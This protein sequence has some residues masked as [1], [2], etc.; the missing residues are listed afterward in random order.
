MDGWDFLMGIVNI[1][2]RLP[3]EK[4]LQQEPV[5]DFDQF[6]QSL[7]KKG[8][9]TEPPVVSRNPRFGTT[10]REAGSCS[11]CFSPGASLLFVDSPGKSSGAALGRPDSG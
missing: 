11:A 5:K 7:E 9:L 3:L 8:L 4:F 1:I 10:N 2:P 6:A